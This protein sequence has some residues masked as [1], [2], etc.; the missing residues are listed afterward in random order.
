MVNQEQKNSRCFTLIHKLT[1]IVVLPLLCEFVFVAVLFSLL[2]L[3]DIDL[4]RVEKAKETQST[5]GLAL[6]QVYRLGVA[7]LSA[8]FKHDDSSALIIKDAEGQ[9]PG[10]LEKLRDECKD[11][12]ATLHNSEVAAVM[13]TRLLD[14]LNTKVMPDPS[15]IHYLDNATK[16]GFLAQRIVTE[17]AGISQMQSNISSHLNTRADWHSMIFGALLLGL[18]IS[19]VISLLVM[20]YI[21]ADLLRR[22]S[23]VTDNTARIASGTQL[24]QSVPGSDEIAQLDKFIHET[25]HAL[26]QAETQRR[27]VMSMLAHDMRVPLSSLA[28]LLDGMAEGRYDADAIAR[29]EKVKKFLPELERVNRMIDDLLT[30]EKLNAGKLR[31]LKEKFLVSDLFKE[32]TETLA[33]DADSK[34]IQLKEECSSTAEI[35]ADKYQLK[36]VLINLCENAIK[37]TAKGGTVSMKATFSEKDMLVEVIDEGSGFPKDVMDRL[38]EKYEQSKETDSRTGFGLGLAI[39]KA[40]IDMHQGKIG[41]RNRADT[42]GSIVY[43]SL[44]REIAS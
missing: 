30:I 19:V 32:V 14:L 22:I 21:H 13:V 17:L 16:L 18:L 4:A 27:E 37:H 41:T 28:L 34:K 39:C 25:N 5:C 11:D 3:S 33:L 36:R 10:L 6:F 1:L 38:F 26:R 44:N 12:A 43:F 9:L 20:R 40:I 23:V 7:S 24:N 31:L 42:A 2:K 35:F 15:P 8:S 29:R